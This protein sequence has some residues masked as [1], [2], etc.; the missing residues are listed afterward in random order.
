LI[1]LL[2]GGRIFIFFFLLSGKKIFFE[3]LRKYFGYLNSKTSKKKSPLNYRCQY[4]TMYVYFEKITLISYS[5]LEQIKTLSIRSLCSFYFSLFNFLSFLAFVSTKSLLLSFFC[6]HFWRKY[7]FFRSGKK[8]II[9]FC[10]I[11]LPWKRKISIWNAIPGKKKKY[12]PFGL[13][14]KKLCI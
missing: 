7:F 8:N 2:F 13:R 4:T 5:I 14:K 11:Y 9:D 6:K 12:Y 10:P 3:F 1:N